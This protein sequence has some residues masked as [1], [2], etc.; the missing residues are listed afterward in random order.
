MSNVYKQADCPCCGYTVYLCH[1]QEVELEEDKEVLGY[2]DR[3]ETYL[4]FEVVNGALVASE[5]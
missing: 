3:C 5:L 4:D 2:C 1:W